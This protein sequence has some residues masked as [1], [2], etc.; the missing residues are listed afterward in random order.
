MAELTVSRDGAGRYC[1]FAPFVLDMVRGVLWRDG[2][3]VHVR[4]KDAEI[5]ITLIERRDTVVEKSEIFKRVW[6]G[7]VVEEN[8]LAR[9]ISEIRRVLGEDAGERS[10]VATFPGRGYRF[11]ADVTELNELPASPAAAEPSAEDGNVEKIA[12]PRPTA[13]NASW[14]PRFRSAAAGIV[15]LLGVGAVIATARYAPATVAAPAV[16]RQFS[17]GPDLQQQPAWSPDGQFIAYASASGGNSDIWIQRALDA[18]PKRVT[19]S[20]SRDW[21]PTWS[22]DGQ[23]LA[24]RSE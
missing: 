16:A 15:I 7:V 24:F 4:P 18:T 1:S 13:S 19:A 2:A 8:N 20:D 11:V 14:L 21:Q 6:P 22:P 3:V 10:Y 17:F 5:L 9:R 12:S 23:W